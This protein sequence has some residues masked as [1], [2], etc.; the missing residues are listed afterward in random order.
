M[1][2]TNCK[3]WRPHWDIVCSNCQR[4]SRY[5]DVENPHCEHCNVV[6]SKKELFVG[7][8][9]KTARQFLMKDRSQV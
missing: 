4:V 8:W 6:L 5:E 1:N 7:A 9:I 3:K 2:S